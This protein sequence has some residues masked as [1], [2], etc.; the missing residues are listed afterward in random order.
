[1]RYYTIPKSVIEDDFHFLQQSWQDFKDGKLKAEEFKAIRVPFGIYEQ[2]ERNT[3]MVRLKTHAGHIS[4]KQ[5]LELSFLARDYANGSIHVT[6]R[7]GLQLHYVKFE[8][9]CLVTSKLHAI[10]LSGRGGGGNT[11]R[12]IACDPY[13]GIAQDDVFDVAPYANA[14]TSKMLGLKDSFNLPRKFKIAFSSSSADRAMATITDVGFIATLKGTQRG[15]IVYIAG[16]MGSKSRLGHKIL[17]FLPDDEV[18]LFAQAVKQVF[19][20]H[21]NRENKHSARLRFLADKIGIESLVDLIHEEIRS[22]REYDDSWRIC[23]EEQK[24]LPE[25]ED[26]KPSLT[27]SALEQ[28]WW[29][30]FVKAQKQSG[31]YYVKVPLT[32]GDIPCTSMEKLA[33]RLEN[34]LEDSICFA[35]N[36]NLI[37]RNLDARTLLDIY[38]LLLEF[39]PQSGR[40]TIFGDMVACTGAATCQLGIARP[41]GA[42]SALEEYLLTKAIDLDVLQDFRIHL[43]GCPNSCGN[44]FTAHLGFFGRILRNNGNPYPG[45]NV[46]VGAIIGEGKTRFARK[47]AAIAA[48]HLPEFVYKVLECYIA[49][50]SRFESFEDWVD[51]GGDAQIAQIAK[52]YEKVPTFEENPKAY[53]DWSSD[54]LFRESLKKNGIGEEN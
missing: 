10:G 21:G 45:Y 5:L 54:E 9:L 49:L 37:L 13:S 50:K 35:Q 3:Y 53:Y 4:P 36:Q 15:F 51:Q 40:A 38:P 7:G 47:V 27:L 29:K 26:S 2:R 8:D 48:F 43:S 25:I 6:T 18:F 41:R 31:Y 44:H 14:L 46:V 24:P 17:D 28:L 32:L 16:G 39:S 33:K 12:V 30:R 1:M 23:V 52:D 42:V 19:D 20:K 11:V 34:S 22:I